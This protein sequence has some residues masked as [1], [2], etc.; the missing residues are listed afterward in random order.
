LTF[1][2]AKG[3]RLHVMVPTDRPAVAL[4]IFARFVGNAAL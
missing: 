4:A 1:A 2:A 3:T